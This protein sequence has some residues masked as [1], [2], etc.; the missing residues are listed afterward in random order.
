MFELQWAHLQYRLYDE[1]FIGTDFTRPYNFL[2]P[3]I[4]ANYN[5][6]GQLNIFANFS[7]TSREPRLKNFY[8]AAEASTPESWGAIVPQFEANSDGAYNFGK[9]LVKPETLN[10]YELGAAYRNGG[11][12]ASAN[13]FYMDFKDEIIKTGQV[14]R[15]GQP[16]TGNAG[17]TVHAGLELLA[18]ARI[19]RA[20]TLS[21]NLMLS[22][23]ELKKYTVYVREDTLII[24]K[25]LAGN[26]IAG[27]PNTLANGRLTYF[28]CGFTASL[29]MQYAGKQYTDNFK[30]DR[31]TVDPYTV[32]NGMMGYT[33]A[34]GSTLGGLSLQVH[35]Q[36]LFDK[37]YL[38]HGEGG[39][40]F[41]AAERQIFVNAKYEL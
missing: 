17:R 24:P 33:F 23:N 1:K 6:T 16:V 18:D 5:F 20:F 31:N 2:N 28:Q 35:A 37:L 26:P 29:A 25:R 34:R 10:D 21:G 12:R 8:D 7:R 40:F 39:Q 14:D 9:P 19:G 22:Q 41:P 32:F 38:M 13:F 36:Y 3:R 15:F 27:F 11:W 4:G 30:N